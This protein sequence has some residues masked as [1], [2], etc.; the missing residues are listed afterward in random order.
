MSTAVL[1]ANATATAT[2]Q[3]WLDALA[4]VSPAV[5]AKPPVPILAFVKVFTERGQLRMQATDY[6]TSADVRVTRHPGE[7]KPFLIP[8]KWAVTTLKPVLGKNKSTWV[9]IRQNGDKV[10]LL[11]DGYEIPV[12]AAPVTEYPDLPVAPNPSALLDAEK[13]STAMAGVAVTASTDDTLPILA[14]VRL[15]FTLNEVVMLATDRY[16]LASDA[17]GGSFSEEFTVLVGAKTWAK[18]AKQLSKGLVGF[19]YD[20]DRTLHVRSGDNVYSILGLDGD[21]PK[22]RSL[23]GQSSETIAVM[24]RAKLLETVTVASKLAERNNPIVIRLKEGGVMVTAD[25]EAKS[26]LVPTEYDRVF[27]ESDERVLAYNPGYLLDMLKAITTDTV[28]LSQP[29]GPKPGTWTAGD[30]SA[31]SD[32]AYRHMIMPVRLPS[33]NK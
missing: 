1:T 18:V 4:N 22:I 25:P 33:E 31:E 6:A 28:R 21:Y 20:G 26:P 19:S 17:V 12:D 3:E 14:G 23:F 8:H 9:T 7:V 16:R 2:G 11:C 13:F 24:N 5:S 15:E 32:L 27:G 10:E 29:A 30:E